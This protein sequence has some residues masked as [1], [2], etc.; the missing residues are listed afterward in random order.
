MTNLYLYKNNRTFS[1][2]M[3]M[4]TLHLHFGPSQ[5]L[6]YSQTCLQRTC[7]TQQTSGNSGHFSKEPSKSQSNSHRKTSKQQT[8]LQPIFFIVDTFFK[9]RVN[10]LG[11]ILLLIADTL[12]LVRKK[13]NIYMFLFDAFLYF[14]IKLISNFSKLFFTHVM[15]L[16]SP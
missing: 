4:H 16:A 5:V 12:R 11:K 10:I 14:N 13:E 1:V 7:Y 6:I 2:H 8:L 15:T 3:F 9:H